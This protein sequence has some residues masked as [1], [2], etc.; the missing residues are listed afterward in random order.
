MKK[1]LSMLLVVAMMLSLCG[2]SSSDYKKAVA[3]FDEG[4]YA[5]AYEMF[6]ALGDYNDSPE[7][8]TQC[9]YELATDLMEKGDYKSAATT[10]GTLGSY[11]DSEELATECRYKYAVDLVASGDYETAAVEFEA[12]G[13]YE[14]SAQYV[15]KAKWNMLYDYIQ[16]NGELDKDTNLYALSVYIESSYDGSSSIWDI[17]YLYAKSPDTFILENYYF[18]T[19]DEMSYLMEFT[20]P[21]TLGHSDTEWEYTF[22][23]WLDSSEGSGRIDSQ[24]G[25][26]INIANS[27][28]DTVLKTETYTCRTVNVYGDE[29]NTNDLKDADFETDE[30]ASAGWFLVINSLP[31]M[32][33]ETGLPITMADLGFTAVE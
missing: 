3:L 7:M 32:L 27:T 16:E 33:A 8:A 14:D 6:I 21:I 15:P 17:V 22:D 28:I 30:L 26:K 4:D 20:F 25:G 23:L 24:W 29:K 10:F 31:D 18:N 12:L 2:C 5:A 1:I 13:D 19:D 9:Q 11:A